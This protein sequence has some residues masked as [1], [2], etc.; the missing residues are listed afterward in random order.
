MRNTIEILFGSGASAG[1]RLEWVKAGS[2][3]AQG[4]YDAYVDTA[5]I[6]REDGKVKMWHLQDFSVPQSADGKTYLSSKNWIEYDC[7]TPQRR[8]LYFSWSSEGMG[9]GDVLYR[10]DEPSDWKPIL[11]GSMAEILWKIACAGKP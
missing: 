5:T 1:T 10:V 8:L 9:A 2:S 3:Q 6:R 4:G 11:P 7:K